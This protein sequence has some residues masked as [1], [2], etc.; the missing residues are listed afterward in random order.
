MSQS[1]DIYEEKIVT[2]NVY[3]PLSLAQKQDAWS[4]CH[5]L[6]D[7]I[8]K[9]E[10]QKK[11]ISGIVKD[12]EESKWVISQKVRHGV[13][14]P[15]QCI[16]K[17][18]YDQSRVEVWHNDKKIEDRVMNYSERQMALPAQ[19]GVVMDAEFDDRE[20]SMDQARDLR[21]VMREERNPMKT[22]AT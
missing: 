7:A 15:E 17:R 11:E 14:L 12:L 16:E 5:K 19:S 8:G 10:T 2:R 1:R 3:I 22:V 9:L 18:F 21:E 4:D 6:D 13:E 20:Q